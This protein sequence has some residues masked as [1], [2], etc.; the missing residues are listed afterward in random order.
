MISSTILRTDAPSLRQQLAEA[1]EPRGQSG[2]SNE[3]CA[4]IIWLIFEY[5]DDE[6]QSEIRY[7]RNMTRV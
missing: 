3:T 4:A 1:V 6:L 7:D 5:F 2:A